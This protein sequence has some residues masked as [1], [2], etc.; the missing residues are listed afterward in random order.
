MKDLIRCISV[1]ALLVLVAVGFAW[2]GDG[3][4]DEACMACHEDLAGALA[5]TVHGLTLRGTPGCQ[6]CHGDG[7]AHMEEGDPSLISIPA[8]KDGQSACLTCH[9]TNMLNATGVTSVHAEAEI[10]CMDC[11]SIHGAAAESTSLLGMCADK[12]CST[13]HIAEASSFRKPY[14]HRLEGDVM[15]CVSCHNPHTG[16]G[17]KSLVLDRS[18]QGPCVTCHA[19]KRGPFTYPHVGDTAGDCMSCHEAHGSTSPMALTRSRVDQLCL[20]CHSPITAGTLGS[21]PPSI[22]ELSNP[23]YR[24]CTVCHVAIHGSNTSPTLF[25]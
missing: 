6:D 14:G 17:A 23:R 18:G 13:C 8:G 16:A 2:A 20:E 7:T 25:R 5:K 12:L 21:M 9:D 4:D 22:H 10:F 11:H 3:G 24:N 1:A 15:N 19:E